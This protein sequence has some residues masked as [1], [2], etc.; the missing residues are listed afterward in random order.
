MNRFFR[1]FAFTLLFSLLASLSIPHPTRAQDPET[2]TPTA[3]LTATPEPTATTE[4]T[5]K[6]TSF[7]RPQMVIKTYK[8][9]RTPLAGQD[10]ELSIQLYNA[11]QHYASNIQV[12]FTSGELIPLGT[13]GVVVVGE[14]AP[15]NHY[16]VKQSM[17]ASSSALGLI[18][19]EATIS[20]YDRQ[21]NAYN[22]KFTLAVQ[23]GAPPASGGGAFVPTATPTAVGVNRPQIVISAYQ[24]DVNPLQ[25]GS[26]FELTLELHNVGN[27]DA[28]QIT[29]VVGGGSVPTDGSGTPQPGGISGGSG[30]FTN[31]APLGT[32]NVQSLGNLA[33]G[34]KMPAQQMLIVNVSTNP[35]AYPMKITFIYTDEKGQTYQ[36][37]Q[38]ITLLVLNLPKVDVSFYR[39]PGFL[40]TYQPNMLPIQVV[41]LGRSSAVLGNIKITSAGGTLENNQMLVGV[42]EAGGYFTLD[43]TFYPEV[44]GTLELLVTIDYTDDFNQPRTISKTLTVEVME[45]E[46]MPTPEFPGNGGEEI[47]A[48]ESFLDIIWRFILGLFGLDSSAPGGQRPEGAPPVEEPFNAPVRPSPKG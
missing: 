30:E 1:L 14:V 47:P 2:E 46:P 11:G 22:E 36:D 48:Q 41:N 4:P 8:S 23:I 26:N 19:T 18:T 20:Y 5:V 29:M 13:G 31:F 17:R 39:D 40:F 42:L 12:T 44:G 9:D 45:Q 35:G 27:K 3:T 21:G 33:V 25:P 32:S 10:F 15:G 34:A 28:R 24:S 37:D 6:P 43:S 38:V 7:G 16:V